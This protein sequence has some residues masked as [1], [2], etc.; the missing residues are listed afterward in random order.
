MTATSRG[1]LTEG[2]VGRHLIALAVPMLGGTFAITAYNLT[3]AWFVSRL[4]TLPLAAM[5]FTFP[6]AMFVGSIT[7]GLSMGATSVVSHA[8]GEGNHAL[9]Q[10]IATHSLILAGLLVGFF[11]VVGLLTVDPVFRALGASDETLPFVRQFMVVWYAG[12][13]VMVLPMMVYS[14]IRATGDTRFPSLIMISGCALNVVLAPIMIFGFL[15]FPRLELF[16][17]ALATVICNALVLVAALLVMQRRHRL[18]DLSTPSAS[19]LWDSWRRV[20]HIGVPSAATNLLMPLSAAIITRIA[21]GY[22]APV[23]AAIGLAGRI[24]MFAFLIPMALG[25]SQVPFIGQNWGAGRLD[26]INL[27]R[28]Y[29]NWFAICWGFCCAAGLLLLARPVAR[30]FSEDTRVVEVLALYLRLVPVGYGMREVHRYVAFSFIGVACPLSA[31]G[32]NALRVLGLLIPCAYLGSYLFGVRGLFAGTVVADVL[33]ALLALLWA[34]R[35]FHELVKRGGRT[36][37][38]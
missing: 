8:I 12:M 29:S 14:I 4:G 16:G 30:V 33:G 17:A 15:G 25:L 34:Q 1:K 22:G 9:A 18:L 13:V 7:M 36:A 6:V 27:C 32:V 11:S 37:C 19:S 3:D 31:A 2:P 26:R 20:L 21:A 28:R 38:G 10:R 35:V 24:E 5:S 23:I